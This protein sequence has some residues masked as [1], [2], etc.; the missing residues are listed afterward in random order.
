[1]KT[2]KFNIKEW[3]DTRLKEDKSINE[4]STYRVYMNSD[5]DEPKKNRL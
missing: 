3:K 5:M 4:G 1:M 2:K